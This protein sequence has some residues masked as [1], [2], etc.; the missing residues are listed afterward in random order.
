MSSATQLSGLASGFDWQTL[1]DKLIAAERTPET[2]HRLGH[3]Y[4]RTGAHGSR[5][6]AVS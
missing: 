3:A 6:F 5:L 1:V 4:R 2:A